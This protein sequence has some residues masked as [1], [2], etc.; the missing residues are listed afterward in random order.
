MLRFAASSILLTVAALLLGGAARTDAGAA[1]PDDPYL[2]PFDRGSARVWAVGDGA[3][4]DLA[5]A[6]VSRLIQHG[7][8]DRFLYLG[9]VYESGTAGEFARNY[10]P[11]FGRFAEIT[12]PTI[13][14]HEAPNVD[15]GYDPYWEGVH[16]AP[17][18]SFYSI[19]VSGWQILSL[20]SEIDYGR[21][22][23]Q[24]RW[25][26]EETAA[27]GNCRLA[28]WHRPRYSAGT[29]HRNDPSLQP[30]WNAL[31]GRARLIVN[32]HEHSMQRFRPRE[33]ITELV[34]G[35]GGSELYPIDP[36]HAGLRFADDRHRGA[37][38]L[39]LTSGRA[40]YAFVATSGKTLDSGSVRCRPGQ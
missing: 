33:G 21:D 19:R 32:G 26:K 27:G 4:S 16:G 6:R 18:P 14:N 40:S 22:S 15:Q 9:D 8:P 25:L 10:E 30:L 2:P 17:P 11:T 38:R 39:R 13:G 37:L 3:A 5:G 35:A 28:F 23:E 31:S 1:V 24:V 7:E 34:A 29:V 20:N 12:A 36:T